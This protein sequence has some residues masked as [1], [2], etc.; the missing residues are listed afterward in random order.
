[1]ILSQISLE[2]DWR[3]LPV[4][5]RNKLA[6]ESKTPKKQAGGMGTKDN[7]AAKTTALSRPNA[8]FRKR[9]AAFFKYLSISL[10]I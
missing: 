5:K 10:D 8:A 2:S 4:F 9:Q 6:T 7:I 3:S 1:M